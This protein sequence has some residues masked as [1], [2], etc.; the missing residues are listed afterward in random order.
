MLISYRWICEMAEMGAPPLELARRLTFSG[1]EVE[2]V[3]HVGVLSEK[4]VVAEV[5]SKTPHPSRESLSVVEVDAGSGKLQVVCGAPNCPGPSGRVVLA[6]VGST[7][8]E[9]T[10]ESRKLGGV[11]SHGML[12]SEHELGIGPDKD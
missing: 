10:L 5:V 9:I 3:E 1:L 12:V 8:G 2:G 7:V 6:E 4:I 11:M